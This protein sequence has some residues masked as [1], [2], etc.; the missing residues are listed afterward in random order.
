ML[1]G[2]GRERASDTIDPGVGIVLRARPGDELE[3]AEPVLEL[4]YSDE[5]RL[6]EAAQLATQAIE[7]ADTPPRPAP[8]V[9]DEIRA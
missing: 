6:A 1:L 5:R 8:L 2:A 7:M 3:A 4:H 9:L